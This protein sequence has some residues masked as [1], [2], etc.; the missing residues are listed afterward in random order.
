MSSEL[1]RPSQNATIRRHCHVCLID[2]LRRKK[3]KVRI[4]SSGLLGHVLQNSLGNNNSFLIRT[5]F[6]CR[7]RFSYVSML[8]DV[9]YILDGIDGIHLAIMYLVTDID[10]AGRHK[11]NF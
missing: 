2:A 10:V 1:S 8:S 5:V 9:T 3:Q 6:V 11:H 4:D 7:L